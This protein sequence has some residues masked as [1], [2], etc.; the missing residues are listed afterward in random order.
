M[1]EIKKLFLAPADKRGFQNNGKGIV[2]LW[3]R[4]KAEQGLQ[5]AYGHFC[6]NLETISA[7]DGQSRRFTRANDF[8]EQIRAALNKDQNV[9]CAHF[10]KAVFIVNRLAIGAS[11][12]LDFVGN[13]LGH[14]YG[15]VVL[16]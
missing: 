9:A 1:R 7:R 3:R 10:A 5:I 11:H 13:A 15:F 16:A 6:T 4:K 2:V 8:F 12:A 14:Q